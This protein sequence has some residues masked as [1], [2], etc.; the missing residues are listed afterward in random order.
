MVLPVSEVFSNKSGRRSRERK[1]IKGTM[2]TG[3]N[4]TNTIMVKR[5]I[6][7]QVL[8]FLR[9]PVKRNLSDQMAPFDLHTIPP[10]DK[11]KAQ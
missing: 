11:K 2:G 9:K 6:F 4:P 10:S 7:R 8:L 1:F 3:R 5:R